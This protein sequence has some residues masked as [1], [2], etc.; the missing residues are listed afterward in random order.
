MNQFTQEYMIRISEFLKKRREEVNVY[1]ESKRVFNALISTD[2]SDVKVVILGQDPYHTPDV[3]DGLAFSSN[4]KGYKPPSLK[5]IFKEVENDIG[6][7]YNKDADNYSLVA[8]AMQGVLLL[9]TALTVEERAPASHAKIGW[10]K[11]VSEVVKELL[12]YKKHIVYMIW[13]NHSKNFF[14]KLFD[15]IEDKHTKNKIKE[16]NLFLLSAHPSPLSA[17]RGFYGNHHFSKCNKYLVDNG[18]ADIKW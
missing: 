6:R 16:N 1:P 5:N 7:C 17:S 8:W 12:F 15:T 18:R 9:N 3:A 10:D 2:F 11:F 13:G 4:L 14:V